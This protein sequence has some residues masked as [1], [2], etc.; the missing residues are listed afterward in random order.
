MF[1]KSQPVEHGYPESAYCS[2]ELPFP[3]MVAR[4]L[5]ERVC[6]CIWDFEVLIFWGNLGKPMVEWWAGQL[7][8]Y[9]NNQGLYQRSCYVLFLGLSSIWVASYLNILGRKTGTVE[10]TAGFEMSSLTGSLQ[11][12]CLSKKA[13]IFVKDWWSK[14]PTKPGFKMLWLTFRF[15]CFSGQI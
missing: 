2:K 14:N 15:R 4:S 1:K 7:I 8:R 5:H 3:S 11:L 6:P 13:I 10:G 9:H 12:N